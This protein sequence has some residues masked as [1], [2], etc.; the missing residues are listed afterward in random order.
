MDSPNS[1][2]TTVLRSQLFVP[3]LQYGILAQTLNEDMK[4]TEQTVCVDNPKWTSSSGKSCMDYSILGSDCSD[5][6]TNG[7]TA[8]EA[9]RVACNNCPAN[10][11]LM[12]GDGDTHDRL[13]SPV[14]E[15]YEPSYSSLLK[16]SHWNSVSV[17]RLNTK[18]PSRAFIS[19][20]WAGT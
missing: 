3:P 20:M 6:G 5:T 7:T 14:E 16:D 1:P 13:P 19:A 12:K 11:K 17:R 9:C 8:T 18:N 10:I 2:T 4:T 15:T